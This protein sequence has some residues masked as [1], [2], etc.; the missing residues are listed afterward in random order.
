MPIQRPITQH[1]IS[2]MRPIQTAR[3]GAGRMYKDQRYYQ[4]LVQA[5]M[6]TI[7]NEMYDLQK[8]TS[9]C[10]SASSALFDMKRVAKDQA[11]IFKESR[12]KLSDVNVIVEVYSTSPDRGQKLSFKAST[13]KEKNKQLN[14][15]FAEIYQ[16]DKT[17]EELYKSLHKEYTEVNKKFIY[18]FRLL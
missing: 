7:R 16:R 4:A 8:N 10:R 2:G 12:E 14:N 9:Q 1:G 13:I 18:N 6:Q 17:D 11:N 15:E 5:H 3:V